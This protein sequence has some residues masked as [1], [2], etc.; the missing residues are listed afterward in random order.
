MLCCGSLG[1]IVMW[2]AC[3]PLP[4]PVYLSVISVAESY[5]SEVAVSLFVARNDLWLICCNSQPLL[6]PL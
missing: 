4:L 1:M 2:S 6:N 3:N 5:S